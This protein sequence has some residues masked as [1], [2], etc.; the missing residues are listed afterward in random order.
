MKVQVITC[1]AM[2][3]DFRK[4]NIRSRFI[5]NA[6]INKQIQNTTMKQFMQKFEV[7]IFYAAEYSSGSHIYMCV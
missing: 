7:Q 4:T 2:L 3:Y 1:T 6:S 5:A